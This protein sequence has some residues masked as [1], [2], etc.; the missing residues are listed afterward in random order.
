MK[1]FFLFSF[2][3]YL[4]SFNIVLSQTFS[5]KGTVRDSK[6]NP[7]I[8]ANVFLAKKAKGTATDK[9]GKFAIKNLKPGVYALEISMIGYKKEV[10][11]SITIKNSDV[12]LDIILNEELIQT[13]Q[14]I[15]TGSKY[16]RKLSE[17]PVS[18][19]ILSYDKIADRNYSS[20]EETL[21]NI[22]G[23]TFALDQISIRGSSGFS[24]G[25]G[26]RVLAAIDG[27]PLHSGDSGEI[28]WEVLPI[29]E[30]NGVEIIKSGQSSLYGSSAIGG[31]VNVITKD[32]SSYSLYHIKSN[33]GFYDK[34]K[35][36]EW[37]WNKSLRTFSGSSLSYS[38]SFKNLS[39]AG[40]FYKYDNLSYR[41]NDF[42][43]RYGYYYKIRYNL[44]SERTLSLLGIGLTQ[45]RGSFIYWKSLKYATQ[46]PETDYGEEVNS[47]RHLIAL[48]YKS[49]LTENINLENKVSYYYTKWNDNSEAKNSSQTDLFRNEIQTVFFFDSNSSAITGFEISYG[50]V[51]SN[52]FS[53]TKAYNAGLY[54]QLDKKYKEKFVL[55]LGLRLDANKNDSLK[56]H[57]SLSPKIGSLYKFS[58]T[59]SFR[60]SSGLSFRAPSL[61]ENF[62][63]T[64][65]SGITVEPNPN[66]KPERAFSNEIGFSHNFLGNVNYDLA[67]FYNYYN[68]LIEPQINRL[69]GKVSF[70]NI[71]NANIYGIETSL[72]GSFFENKLESKLSAQILEAIDAN[73]KKP[74][75]YRHNTTIYFSNDLKI[76]PFSAGVDFRFA[77]KSK[78]IDEDLTSIVKDA[79]ARTDIYVLDLRIGYAIYFNNLFLKTNFNV[80][81]ALNYY[82]VEMSGNLAPIRNYSLNLELFF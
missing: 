28:V 2:S 67:F 30:I 52:I 11:D 5:I 51:N 66:L 15:V 69:N 60:F 79:N 74:L 76:L 23:I 58:E 22:P 18:A 47:N 77:S 35:Y 57:Y 59:T 73:T 54:S 48:I 45:R 16:Q 25:V 55:S 56:S 9:K 1:K 82:Y 20:L 46:P 34:T 29:N 53:K 38:N 41:Q 7:L 24:R 14:I 64:S 80:K 62:T 32:N 8:G 49:T 17:T 81:N 6:K 68:K 72:S 21:R 13:D 4:I 12:D 44:G 50:Q 63:R 19:E 33:F 27:I 43:K 61:A 26:A 10:I 42:V 39:F 36:K 37:N 65:I 78:A 40:N 70:V 71:Q 31:V 3:L 75:K